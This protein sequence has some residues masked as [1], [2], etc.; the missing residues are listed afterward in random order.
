MP[1]R[2]VAASRIFAAAAAEP[3][4]GY[5]QVR[6]AGESLTGRVVEKTVRSP[7][8]PSSASP[9]RSSSPGAAAPR[10]PPVPPDLRQH[11]RPETRVGALDSVPREPVAVGECQKI[12]E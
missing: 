12:S 6:V 1:Y 3:P 5:L 7:R 9:S 11:L 8:S 4:N 2:E 10:S